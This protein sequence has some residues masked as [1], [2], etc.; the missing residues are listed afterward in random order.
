MTPKLLLFDVFGTVVNWRCSITQQM[1]DFCQSCGYDIDCA[2]FALDW[3]AEYQ[4]GMAKIRDGQR[5]YVPLDVLHRENLERVA[6]RYDLPLTEAEAQQLTRFWHRLDPWPDSVAGLSALRA[7]AP[8]AALSNGN[9]ALMVALSRH[10]G[11]T[12]DAVLG[13]DLAQAYKPDPQVYLRAAAAMDLS[14]AACMMVAAHNDDLAAARALGM[15]T[16]FVA[17]QE[18]YGPAQVK[19]RVATADWDIVTNTL[20]GVASALRVG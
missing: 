9:I 4:P 1:S 6:A 2:Q 5:G 11:L 15:Q 17:R 18:E 13:A 3:R 14:P 16:A 10:A 12:W 20:S 8:V 19:D 7:L